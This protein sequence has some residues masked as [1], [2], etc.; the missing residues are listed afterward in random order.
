MKAQTG[1]D[2][3]V[4]LAIL[5]LLVVILIVIV[6][7]TIKEVLVSEGEKGACE[8][9][10]VMSSLVKLGDWSLIPPECRANRIDIDLKY[11]D[12]FTSEAKIR[13]KE[14]NTNPTKYP[15]IV[16]YFK[17]EKDTSKVYEW[18]LNKAVATE[19]NDCWTKVFKG[20]LPLFDKWWT[21]YDFPWQNIDVADKDHG[22]KIFDSFFGTFHQAPVNCI[23]CSRIKFSDDV[24]KM[25]AGKNID[26]MDAWLRNNY[27]RY[28]GK[29]Y[30]EELTEG[31]SELNSLFTPAYEFRVDNPLAVL[32]EKI[33][34]Y[35]IVDAT[36]TSVWE[37]I[38]GGSTQ[39]TFNFLKLVPYTQD[40]LINQP[41]KGGNGYQG[42]GCTFVLD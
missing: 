39:N 28:G 15:G 22:Q 32:Y 41:V 36:I 9:S 38:F 34:Y 11:L 30:Y 10:L 5:G 13:I 31:Q 16:N 37:T 21:L 24:K 1:I 27:P 25:F 4:G 12:R 2:T 18:A 14:Y 7:P 40:A 6:F 3:L 19:M 17:D 26:S 23:V 29:S 20:K 33:Y 35:H 8:W 42:E